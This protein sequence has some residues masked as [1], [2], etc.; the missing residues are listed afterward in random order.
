MDGFWFKSTRFEIEPGED[1]E[2]NPR[3]YGR[4]LAV[5]LEEQLEQRGY[6]VE[7][8]IAEDWGRC[9]MCSRSPFSLWVGAVTYTTWRISGAHRQIWMMLSG[10]A[11]RWQKFHFGA[12]SF[13]I[14][15]HL[16]RSISSTLIWAP[17][18]VP[19]PRL[20]WLQSHKWA[21][22]WRRRRPWMTAMGRNRSTAH[23]LAMFIA[24]S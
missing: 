1:D 16:L 11:S 15:I 10:I 21:D 3:I 13:K 18:S 7:P 5:W 6:N 8:V 4:Q 9:L 24:A 17:S 20:C 19:S 2:I 23:A 14:W 22:R 12:G